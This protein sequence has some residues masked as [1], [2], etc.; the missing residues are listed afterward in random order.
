M[1]V[2]CFFQNA[3]FFLKEI[4]SERER[5]RDRQIEREILDIVEI[6]PFFNPNVTCKRPWK[7]KPG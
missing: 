4:G 1:N 7:D 3:N 5:E 2:S 6:E